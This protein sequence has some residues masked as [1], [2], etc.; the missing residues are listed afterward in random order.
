MD[1]PAEQTTTYE[2]DVSSMEKVWLTNDKQFFDMV[3]SKPNAIPMFTPDLAG[4]EGVCPDQFVGLYVVGVLGDK[5]DRPF[6]QAN[7]DE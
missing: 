5:L 6:Q 4:A 2:Y 3:M 7:Q 1:K